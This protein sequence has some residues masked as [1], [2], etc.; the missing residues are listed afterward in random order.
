MCR[1]WPSM[2]LR[3]GGGNRGGRTSVAPLPPPTLVPPPPST[4]LL[5]LFRCAR[6][7]LTFAEESE[8]T[9][10]DWDSVVSTVRVCQHLQREDH[11]KQRREGGWGGETSCV[12]PPAP[13]FMT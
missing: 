11:E 6:W 8:P 12:F 7:S 1:P 2:C 13:R 10:A 3:C 4:R 9:S 5:R